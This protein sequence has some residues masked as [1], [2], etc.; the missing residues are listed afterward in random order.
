MGQTIVIQFV[1]LD[2]VVEDPD[3]SDGTPY[4]GWAMRHGPAAI[5]GDK[6]R[7]GPLMRTATLLFGHRTWAHF[8]TLW[9]PRTDDFSTAM[10]AARKAVLSRTEVD[11]A[12]WS[13]TTQVSGTLDEWLDHE[14]AERDV[15][16]IGSTGVAHHLLAAGRV[17]Q[18]R[19][20]TFPIAL[21]QGRRLFVQPLALTQVS[22]EAT[23]F[24]TL[25]VLEPDAQPSG[26]R[27]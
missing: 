15:V 12:A 3:G 21:G 24:T 26:N 27:G 13:S 8:S 18:L 19:L 11:T 4:G 23:P 1:T 17:Y 20:L 10:N 25:T 5:G 16:L 22:V 14:L 7:L 6:F 9:P 2:G